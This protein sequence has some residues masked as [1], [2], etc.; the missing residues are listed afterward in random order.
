MRSEFSELKNKKVLVAGSGNITGLNVIRSLKDFVEVVGYDMAT[1]N[2]SD[3][4]CKNITVPRTTDPLYHSKILEIVEKENVFAIIPS[5][6]HDARSLL[7]I[8]KDLRDRGVYLNADYDVAVDC[9][10][11]KKTA[12][13]FERNGIKT[14]KI[15]S[16][17]DS[18]PLVVRKETVGGTK[19]FVHIIE[20]ESDKSLI[21]ESDWENAIVTRMLKGEE[22][23]IDVVC[24]SQSETF[25]IVPRLRREVRSGMVHFAE[26]VK[27]EE[28]ISDTLRI[29]SS[30]SL[31][32]INCIQ[33]IYDGDGCHFFEIN[34]RPGSGMDLS[35]NAGVNMPLMWIR[36]L[37]GEKVQYTEPDWGL[38]MLRYF[39]GY[40]FK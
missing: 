11:K 26:I 7:S 22:Y 21:S 29:V 32:G 13:I 28:V 4:F 25:S 14:P 3:M 23:T 27:N 36:S 5:N 20:D 30:L 39:D 15:L 8:S 34:P 2:A 1:Q 19:K 31:T 18:V 12:Q 35:T 38:K 24:S 40:F 17:T 6:D 10:D 9:L 37:I 16:R 33:C